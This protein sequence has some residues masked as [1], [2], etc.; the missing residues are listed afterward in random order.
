MGQ[1]KLKPNPKTPNSRTQRGLSQQAILISFASVCVFLAVAY[2]VWALSKPPEPLTAGMPGVA[3]AV[4]VPT[5]GA[6]S[7]LPTVEAP[8]MTVGVPGVLPA[9]EVPTVEVPGVEGSASGIA[10]LRSKPHLVFRSTAYGTSSGLMSV[11]PLDNPSATRMLTDLVCE[12]A[13]IT[14][15][16]GLCLDDVSAHIIDA[17]MQIQHTIPLEGFPSRTRVSADGRYAAMTQF[18]SGH[19]YADSTFSTQTNLIDLANNSVIANIEDFEVW[20]DDTLFGAPDF[21]F[22]GVTFA[23]DSNTFY[24][25]LSTDNKMYLVLGDISKGSFTVVHE[26]I[27]C[28]SLSPDNTRV[29]FKK[30]MDTP[31]DQLI[32]NIAV[33]DLQTMEETMLAE[34]R[35]VDDQVEWLDNDHVM[36]GV[37]EQNPTQGIGDNLWVL[38]ADGSGAPELFVFKGNSPTVIH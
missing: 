9:V 38:P 11:V 37:A 26:G 15:E 21:N 3:P 22:W 20:R 4:E 35:H 19:S 16:H 28:P 23:K 8:T 7:V 6:P 13:Y 31:D 18:V 10:E 29:A 24:A 32:W 1:P 34:T 27:E 14:R 25:T 5:V 12:R 33:L 2:G 17:D 30:K 36:Y